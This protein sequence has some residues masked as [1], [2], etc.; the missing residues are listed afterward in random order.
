MATELYFLLQASYAG[1]Y[2]EELRK[3]RYL[4]GESTVLSPEMLRNADRLPALPEADRLP[5]AAD[6]PDLVQRYRVDYIIT[7]PPL[8]LD[9]SGGEAPREEL[10]AGRAELLN[11]LGYREIYHGQDYSL[12]QR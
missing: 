6:L 5:R 12:W 2:A 1:K 9:G 10:I 11:E 4:V 8:W 7:S 3:W